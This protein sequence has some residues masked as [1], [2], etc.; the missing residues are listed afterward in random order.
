VIF[1]SHLDKWSRIHIARLRLVLLD[2][3]HVGRMG[4]QP[5]QETFPNGSPDPVDVV[6]DDLHAPKIGTG[7]SCAP[8]ACLKSVIIYAQ[9]GCGT[10]LL[11]VKKKARTGWFG[12]LF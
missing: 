8:P 12:N 2:T 1:I 11:E 7:C 4:L 10:L 6:T 9:W 3:D 5:F